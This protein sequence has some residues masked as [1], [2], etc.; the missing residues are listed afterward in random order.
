MGPRFSKSLFWSTATFS[1]AATLLY[2][3]LTPAPPQLY[4]PLGW[5]KLQHAAAFGF[6]AFLIF[7]SLEARQKPIRISSLF[8]FIIA[9]S[10]GGIIEL[11]QGWLTLNRKAEWLDLAADSL[12]ACVVAIIIHSYYRN[13]G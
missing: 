10:F 11:L 1:G 9:T 8:A 7:K 12:G 6:L 13:R 3:C 2:L 4:G 5:D